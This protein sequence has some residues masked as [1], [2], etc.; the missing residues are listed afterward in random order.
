M[1][2]SA[3]VNSETSSMSSPE[4]VQTPT[5]A[6]TGTSCPAKGTGAD[7]ASTSFA[8]SLSAPCG[9]LR[10]GSRTTNSSPPILAAVSLLR[11]FSRS[12]RDGVQWSQ[13]KLCR[14]PLGALRV[15]QVGQQNHELVS[16]HSGRGIALA[17]VLD[18]T[19]RQH[20]QHLVACQVTQPVIDLLEVVD[21]QQQQAQPRFTALGGFQGK[22]QAV[23]QHQPGCQAG[24]RIVLRQMAEAIFALAEKM[25]LPLQASPER[26]DPDQYHQRPGQHKSQQHKGVAHC[27]PRPPLHHYHIVRRPHQNPEGLGHRLSSP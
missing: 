22:L 19:I 5:L 24:Q 20:L 7:R 8:A 23:P 14:K 12:E 10:S 11:M 13:Y 17:N 15:A 4:A 21:V 6:E 26:N 18:D 3:F 27:P 9:S 1:A 16:P 25:G 2:S